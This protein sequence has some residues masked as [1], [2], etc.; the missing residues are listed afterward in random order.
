MKS[1]IFT[2]F[3]VLLLTSAGFSQ[4][5]KIGIIHSEVIMANYPEFKRA[6]DQLKIEAQRWEAE[7]SP[8][9]AD[10][11]RIKASILDQQA[12]LKAGENTF[13]DKRK[14]ELTAV[15]DSMEADYQQ[16]LDR[17]ITFEQDRFNQR[18]AE[19]LTEVFELVNQ[20]IE[21]IGKENN[22]DLIIDSSNGSVVYARD[23]EDLTDQLLRRLQDK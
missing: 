13:S 2:I 19:L 16:R 5:L 12:R 10:M 20:T 8:W 22:F 1:S 11:E 3:S 15:I 17:Q 21:E 9:E 18:R 7:R 6:E 14:A 4:E 23:P